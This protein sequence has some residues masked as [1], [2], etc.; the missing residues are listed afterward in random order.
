MSLSSPTPSQVDDLVRV[1]R[2]WADTPYAHLGRLKGH[3]C[4]CIGLVIMVAQELGL[5]EFDTTEYG[6]DPQPQRMEEGLMEYLDQVPIDLS[7]AKKG[8]LPTGLQVG[9]ILHMRHGAHPRHLGMIMP[10]EGGGVNLIH[11]FG[12][13]GKV[14]EHNL[15][16]VWLTLIRAGYRYRW[17]A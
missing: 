14:V 4:D 5:T 7:M 1:A 16:K 11:A 2:S 8:L 17:P 12:S 10:R 13:M 6:R 15:D 9:D 3:A